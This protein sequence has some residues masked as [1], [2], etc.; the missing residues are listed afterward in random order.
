MRALENP[1][2]PRKHALDSEN[3]SRKL[4]VLGCWQES[5]IAGQKKVVFQFRG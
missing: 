3:L 2:E 5:D 4:L 1:T